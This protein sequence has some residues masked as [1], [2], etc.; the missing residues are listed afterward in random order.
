MKNT[1]KNQTCVHDF[2]MDNISCTFGCGRYID[3]SGWCWVCDD[4]S[5]NQ[6]EC[7][8]CGEA[9]DVDPV[10]GEII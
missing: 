9:V 10:T 3:E 2:D 1:T 7:R 5:V 6:A 8:K 4:N